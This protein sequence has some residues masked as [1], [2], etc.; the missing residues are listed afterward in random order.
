[1]SVIDSI[2]FLSHIAAG[3]FKMVWYPAGDAKRS[4]NLDY[5]CRFMHKDVQEQFNADVGAKFNITSDDFKLPEQGITLKFTV[6]DLTGHNYLAELS[7]RIHVTTKFI[8]PTKQ[9]RG[10][11]R[12]GCA[13][14]LNVAESKNAEL[15]SKNAVSTRRTH[16][17]TAQLKSV[18][19]IVGNYK[20]VPHSTPLLSTDKYYNWTTELVFPSTVYFVDS[21]DHS[22]KLNWYDTEIMHKC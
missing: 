2:E 9:I 10:T 6:Y 15:E 16:D 8:S 11:V 12:G 13:D 18:A 7:K 20:I 22:V 5:A 1:M 14:A 3:H 19:T 21:D 4:Y 17:Y